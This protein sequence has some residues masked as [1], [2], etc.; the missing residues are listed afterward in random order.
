L[1]V[2]L[3]QVAVPHLEQLER[4]VGRFSLD[5]WEPRLALEGLTLLYRAYQKA[6]DEDKAF[7][8]T[9]EKAQKLFARLCQLDPMMALNLGK[10]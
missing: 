2:K 4:E 1:N 9:E 5:E 6:L 8:D 7:P 10:K 3:P